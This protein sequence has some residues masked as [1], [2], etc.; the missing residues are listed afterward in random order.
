MNAKSRQHVGGQAGADGARSV[1][2]SSS[3]SVQCPPAPQVTMVPKRGSL[4]MV[5]SN[6]NTAREHF[7]NVHAFEFHRNPSCAIKQLMERRPYIFRSV[8]FK[9]NKTGFAR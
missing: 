8:E 3:N 2:T 5:T 7:L 6:S 4:K 1:T 9:R